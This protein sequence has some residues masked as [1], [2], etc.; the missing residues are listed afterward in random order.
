MNINDIVLML[1]LQTVSSDKTKI[2]N[3]K[4]SENNKSKDPVRHSISIISPSCLKAC[5]NFD[6]SHTV[7]GQNP[8]PPG[9][10]KTL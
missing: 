5:R 3:R 7:D 9:K 6:H 1:E 2:V 10:V 4:I 8:A